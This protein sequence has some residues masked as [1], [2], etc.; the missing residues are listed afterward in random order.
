MRPVTCQG[1]VPDLVRLAGPDSRRF[2]RQGWRWCVLRDI[3]GA[4]AMA[5]KLSMLTP[6]TPP[7][8]FSFGEVHGAG[9]GG[10]ASVTPPPHLGVKVLGSW[11]T[12]RIPITLGLVRVDFIG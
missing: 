7:L 12:R 11:K 10:T 4:V 6:A 3:G 1:L 8:P 9:V 5:L 2:A